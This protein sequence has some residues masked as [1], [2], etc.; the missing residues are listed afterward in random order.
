MSDDRPARAVAQRGTETNHYVIHVV[1]VVGA[2]GGG[3]RELG[4]HRV[5]RPIGELHQLM[6][7]SVGN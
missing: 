7:T 1:R 3:H 4:V 6:G 2:N 5:H